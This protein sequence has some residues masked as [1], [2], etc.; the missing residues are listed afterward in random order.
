M[1]FLA[2]FS[3][4]GRAVRC[5]VRSL[6]YFIAIKLQCVVPRQNVSGKHEARCIIQPD[7]HAGH[8][9]CIKFSNT[10]QMHSYSSQ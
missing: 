9:L 1:A 3:L 2:V 6:S 5:L 10:S 7:G 8:N 4:L